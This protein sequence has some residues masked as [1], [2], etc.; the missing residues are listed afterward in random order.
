MAA[1]SSGGGLSAERAIGVSAGVAVY[2]SSVAEEPARGGEPLSTGLACGL[3][4]AVG[5]RHAG[6]DPGA[7]QRRRDRH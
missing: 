2:H 1:F 6:C 3:P 7:A 5:L 4:S